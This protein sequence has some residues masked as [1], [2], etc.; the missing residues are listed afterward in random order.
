MVSSFPFSHKTVDKLV[1]RGQFARQLAKS[2]MEIIRRY[3]PDYCSA[4]ANSTEISDTLLGMKI[5]PN[6]HIPQFLLGF[7]W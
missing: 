3:Q 7:Y 5:L 2:E 4:Q 6:A 1:Q